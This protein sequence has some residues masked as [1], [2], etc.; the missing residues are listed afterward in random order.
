MMQSELLM[1]GEPICECVTYRRQQRQHCQ[2][3]HLNWF[4]GMANVGGLK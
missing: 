2:R 3:Q 4:Q 1:D